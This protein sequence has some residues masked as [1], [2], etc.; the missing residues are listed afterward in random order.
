MRK[1]LRDLAVFRSRKFLLSGA[2]GMLVGLMAWYCYLPQ[3]RL[4]LK[5]EAGLGSPVFS[6]DG[7]LLACESGESIGRHHW[8]G[9]IRLWD[10]TSGKELCSIPVSRVFSPHFGNQGYSWAF[11]ADSKKLAILNKGTLRFWDARTG[12]ELPHPPFP[13]PAKRKPGESHIFSG[14]DGRL[15]IYH[16]D[17]WDPQPNPHQVQDGDTAEILVE[18]PS[19]KDARLYRD[20]LP[21]GLITFEGE[22]ALVWQFPSGK[23]RWRVAIPEPLSR[24]VR[25][26][27]WAMTPDAET[28]V[29][30]N[31]QVH[32]WQGDESNY[33]TLDVKADQSPSLSPDGKVLAVYYH[34]PTQPL[35]HAW[36]ETWL[37]IYLPYPTGFVKLY[38]LNSGWEQ[39]SIAYA[40]YAS[41]SPDGS[42]LA[43][44]TEDN[45]IHIYDFPLHKPIGLI[46]AIALLA[47]V[48]AWL[49]S[50]YTVWRWR[51]KLAQT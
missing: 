9:H 34:H 13:D 47:G 26:L 12:T 49:F 30:I 29:Y 11:T 48:A 37:G 25:G 14:P 42:T 40:R 15:L 16:S 20:A 5:K 17:I 2:F 44:G 24:P 35:F 21:G 4:V 36:L 19:T 1:T 39:E 28:L 8:S 45:T 18:I 10:L 7:K 51:R 46:A 31:G 22:T 43:V 3:P 50:T 6:P 38:D 27:D 41:F 33:Y 32:V 23:L